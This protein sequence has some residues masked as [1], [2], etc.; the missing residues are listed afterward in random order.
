MYQNQCAFGSAYLPL[1][2]CVAFFDLALFYKVI[3]ISCWFFDYLLAQT[4]PCPLSHC[5][6]QSNI[7]VHISSS[8][9]CPAEAHPVTFI[10]TVLSRD[11]RKLLS[12]PLKQG[13][14]YAGCSFPSSPNFNLLI[15]LSYCFEKC[16]GYV[17][18]GA[19]KKSCLLIMF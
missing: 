18:S 8:F 10:S 12:V 2:L 4:W 7:P 13:C 11:R 19:Q 9:S 3:K 14:D 6:L 16:L 15:W 17:V 5:L 1:P